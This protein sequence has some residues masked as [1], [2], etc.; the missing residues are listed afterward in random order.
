MGK[1][2]SPKTTRLWLSGVVSA[3]RDENLTLNHYPKNS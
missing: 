3:C 2:S 1:P